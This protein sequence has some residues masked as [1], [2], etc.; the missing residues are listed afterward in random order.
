MIDLKEIDNLI[1]KFN[2]MSPENF[3]EYL[4]S[5]RE[6]IHLNDNKFKEIISITLKNN[7]DDTDPPI[8]LETSRISEHFCIMEKDLTPFN[9]WKKGINLTHIKSGTRITNIAVRKSKA[10]F[11]ISEL[12]NCGINWDFTDYNDFSSQSNEL[13]EKGISIARKLER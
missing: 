7:P 3:E 2:T 9:G 11:L 6:A 4:L 8:T 1:N 12:E 5:L 13:L 10:L